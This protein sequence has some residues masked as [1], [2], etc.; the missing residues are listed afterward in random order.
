MSESELIV[1]YLQLALLAICARFGG[2][3]SRRLRLPA[4][5]GE[6]MAGVILG[7][8]I[9][10]QLSPSVHDALFPHAGNNH[11]ALA[12]VTHLGICLFVFT[13]GMEVDLSMVRREGRLALMVSAAGIAVPFLVAFVPSLLWPQF[14]G[15]DPGTRPF[16][17]AMFVGAALSITALSLTAKTLIDL[18]LFRTAF[19]ALVMSAAVF[20][21]LVGWILVGVVFSL[22]NLHDASKFSLEHIV[23]MV[24]ATIAFVAVMLTAGRFIC[25]RALRAL[26][27][28]CAREPGVIGLIIGAA[29]LGACFT[30]S[31]GMHG[32]FGAFIVGVVIGQCSSL[33]DETRKSID[34]VVSNFLAPI[35]F[36]SIGLAVNFVEHFSLP[37]VLTVLAIASFGK[38]VGCYL[39]ARLQGVASSVALAVGM[40]MNTRGSIEIVLGMIA[41]QDKIIDER[42]FVALAIMALTSITISGRFL[43]KAAPSLVDAQLT[44][45]PAEPLCNQKV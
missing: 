5:V 36:A 24:S 32:L 39:I 19:G 29:L 10:R 3:L 14:L 33:K 42:L 31:I 45:I 25:E 11:T 6:V 8:T 35:F 18:K 40:A 1:F 20:D 38:I 44:Q 37:V 7:P 43:E 21:D 30:Q 4:V 41:L 23:T 2:E 26:Y 9:L 22:D 12:A 16:I 28:H 27:A 34:E 13:A 15:C 17:F